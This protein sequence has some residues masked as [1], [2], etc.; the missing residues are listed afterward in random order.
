MKDFIDRWYLIKGKTMT[1]VKA[2]IV[3]NNW[4]I[5]TEDGSI[6]DGPFNTEHEARMF[7]NETERLWK[8]G[9]YHD[10]TYAN[11]AS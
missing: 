7:I 1:L 9:E 11:Q 10:G 4:W 8:R 3:G 2:E 5:R 6:T